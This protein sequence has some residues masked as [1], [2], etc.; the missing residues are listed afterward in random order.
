MNFERHISF[1]NAQKNP[2]KPEKILGFNSK[3]PVAYPKLRYFL[4]GLSIISKAC[5]PVWDISGILPLLNL[6]KNGLS[7]TI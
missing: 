1:Q 7:V 3:S 2:R 6:R 5:T 4:F